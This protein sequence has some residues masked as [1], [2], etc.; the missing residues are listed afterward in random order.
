MR[1]AWRDRRLDHIV[2]LR[3]RPLCPGA[4]DPVRDEP[5]PYDINSMAYIFDSVDSY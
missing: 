1:N 2:W 4:S 5:Q 3:L